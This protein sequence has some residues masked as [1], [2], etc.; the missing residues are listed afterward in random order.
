MGQTRSVDVI[1]SYRWG[2]SIVIHAHIQLL[3]T[4][5]NSAAWLQEQYYFLHDAL[6]E[7]LKTGLTSYSSDNF[8]QKYRELGKPQADLGNTST[9]QQQ[10]KV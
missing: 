8:V 1:S 2:F 6:V 4:R 5:Y 7:S 9:I 10:F 3:N